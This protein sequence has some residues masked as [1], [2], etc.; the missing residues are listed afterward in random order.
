MQVAGGWL[1]Q[2]P[3]CTWTGA[4]TSQEEAKS[5]LKNHIFSEHRGASP[6]KL[7]PDLAQH[8]EG[9]HQ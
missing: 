2:C 4:T 1:A 7:S 9:A 3:I 5:E 8:V 6:P